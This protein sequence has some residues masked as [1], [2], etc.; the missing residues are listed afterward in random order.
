MTTVERERSP[1]ELVVIDMLDDLFSQIRDMAV[2]PYRTSVKRSVKP[3]SSNYYARSIARGPDVT[4]LISGNTDFAQP[5]LHEETTRDQITEMATLVGK[6]GLYK[7]MGDK[8]YD[9]S[10]R[11]DGKRIW[12]DLFAERWAEEYASRM[13]DAVYLG[14]DHTLAQPAEVS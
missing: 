14:L 10:I 5:A 12:P 6:I 13:T 3:D 11:S 7:V 2:F 1:E 8:I 9:S 4:Y